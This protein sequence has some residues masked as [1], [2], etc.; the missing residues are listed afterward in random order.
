[1]ALILKFASVANETM[2]LKTTTG[3][4]FN[5]LLESTRMQS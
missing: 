3:A 1:M 4:T 5:P 2:D